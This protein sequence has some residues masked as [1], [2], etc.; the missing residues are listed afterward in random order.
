M[1]FNCAFVS[2][3]ATMAK[4]ETL[5]QFLTAVLPGLPRGVTRKQAAEII[6]AELFQISD[7]TLREWPI[8]VRHVNGRAHLDTREVLTRAWAIYCGDDRGRWPHYRDRK[9]AAAE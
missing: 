9:V 4:A 3:E 1:P 6:R 2:L 5:D 7:T 8:A